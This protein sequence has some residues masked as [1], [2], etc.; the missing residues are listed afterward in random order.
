MR[1]ARAEL[2][3][4]LAIGAALAGL[5]AAFGSSGR[6][7]DDL[8]LS[9]MNDARHG[10]R[11]LYLVLEEIG[12]GPRRQRTAPAADDPTDRTLVLAAPS[13]PVTRRETARIVDWVGAGG[14]LVVVC[15]GVVPGA[16][17]PYESPVLD[18]F[19]V[20]RDPHRRIA[21]D[22]LVIGDSALGEGLGRV[23]WPAQWAVAAETAPSGAGAFE[24]LLS[25]GGRCLAGRRK[26]GGSGGE[27]VV[28][29][30]AGLLDNEALGR[31]D[32]AVLAARLLLGRPSVS[33]DEFHHGF[34]DDDAA[35]ELTSALASMLVGTWPGRA[36]LVAALGGAVWI[37]GAAVRL[38]APERDRPPPRRALAEHAEALGRIFERAGARR[39]ALA[40]LAAGA[41]RATGPR[42]GVPSSLP[43]AE[44]VRRLRTAQAPGAAELADAI[45]RAE[46]PRTPKVVEMA[47]VAANLAAAKRRF[48]HGGS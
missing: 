14:R 36:L 16:A 19:G 42:A 39:E 35:A 47:E 7:A 24:E 17:A 13:A 34:R 33:F 10:L 43:P 25:S 6:D 30:D 29:A 38:G 22:A 9:S 12:A 20:S 3:A 5:G 18:A 26:F 37:L 21:G 31:G 27:I 41:R 2:A 15:G 32:N 44:F 48:L 8:R 4:V 46:A 1:S 40:I 23:E 11:A 45:E 28:V